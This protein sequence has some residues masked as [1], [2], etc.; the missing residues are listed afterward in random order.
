MVPPD[1]S[2]PGEGD[3]SGRVDGEP[4]VD[5][6]DRRLWER[7]E[8]G[9]STEGAGASAETEPDR[10][11]TLIQRGLAVVTGFFLG[12]LGFLVGFPL[13]VAANVVLYVAGLSSPVVGVIV[14]LVALQGIAF[15]TV[16]LGYLGFR[17]GLAA[18]QDREFSAEFVRL[19]VPTLRDLGWTALGFFGV[20]GL[21]VVSLFTVSFLDAP[22][23]ER[24][25][26]EVLIQNP[27]LLLVLIPLSFL[28]IGPGEELLFR[29]IIQD[30]LRESFG[31]GT[32][33]FLASAAFAPLHIFALSGGLGALA[34]TIGLLFVPSLVFGITYE[35]TENLLVPVLI[36]GA[37]DALIFGLMYLS[38]AASGMA[39]GAVA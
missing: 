5:Q 2:D 34:T 12:V 11:P 10:S 8:N 26:T 15:P 18:L 32:A 17:H 31:P 13:V 35:A 38:L 16:A 25:D 20:V 14:S 39:I 4:T 3:K 30:R 6:S 7:I 37:Y 9:A 23:A 28:L 1:D 29:G 21:M 33:I 27:E 19:R 36:H 22:T 24:A